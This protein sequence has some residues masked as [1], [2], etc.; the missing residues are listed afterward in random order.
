MSVQVGVLN[1]RDNTKVILVHCSLERKKWPAEH[2]SPSSGQSAQL[3]LTKFNLMFPQ[4]EGFFKLFTD[5]T[6]CPALFLFIKFSQLKKIYFILTKT[7]AEVNRFKQ[8]PIYTKVKIAY[9]THNFISECES[10][11]PQFP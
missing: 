8:I 10:P 9:K 6:N 4:N 5:V 2:Q 1:E 7:L 11:T 3:H